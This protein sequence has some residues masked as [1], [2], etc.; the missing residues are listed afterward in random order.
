MTSVTSSG[1]QC[2]RWDSYYP[3]NHTQYY[4][5]PD[6]FPDVSIDVASNYCRNPG[7]D[8][9]EPKPW[10]YTVDANIR[11]GYCNLDKCGEFN[12]YGK[13]Y[14]FLFTKSPL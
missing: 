7:A 3:H 14:T 4:S 11:W 12:K 1:I 6:N 13:A 10:C 5:N 2:Q 8:D 9:D